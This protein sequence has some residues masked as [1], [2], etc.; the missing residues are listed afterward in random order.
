MDRFRR[1]R[2]ARDGRSVVVQGV[3]VNARQGL[4]RID[5]ETAAVTP[6]VTAV[7]PETLS[8]PELSPDGSRLF[9]VRRSTEAC[10]VFER[11]LQQGQERRVTDCDRL[12]PLAISPDGK[13]VAQARAAGGSRYLDTVVVEPM[14]G[15][16]AREIYRQPAG[17]YDIN[18]VSWMPDGS[19]VVVVWT[20]AVSPAQREALLVPVAGGPP[21]RLDLPP[22]VAER[23]DVHPD[24]KQLAFVAGER[25]QEVWVLENFLPAASKALKR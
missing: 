25:R 4:Y 20:K 5:V 17:E 8:W 7:A 1:P 16:P 9:F 23:I 15:G 11:D 13:Q 22:T 19:H 12:G 24:G 21:T 18:G 2:W 10:G 3:D 14:A 6:L